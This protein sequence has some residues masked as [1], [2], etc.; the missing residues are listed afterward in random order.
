[1]LERI[2][3]SLAS[4]DITFLDSIC[5]ERSEAV[6]IVI[7]K[8]KNQNLKEE[9]YKYLQFVTLGVVVLG[10][11]VLLDPFSIMYLIMIALGTGLS[12]FGLICIVLIAKKRRK[13][14]A[15]ES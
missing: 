9:F 11:S 10:I 3:I 5:D 1:M 14:N 15:V 2:T 8:F 13:N 12:L 7:K 4:D 6:R